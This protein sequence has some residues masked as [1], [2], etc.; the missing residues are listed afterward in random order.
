STVL[1]ESLLFA[2]TIRENIAYGW[3]NVTDADIEAAARLA[4]IHDFIATLP[5][6]Y[7]TVVGERGVTLSGGQR[8]RVAIARAAVRK[9]S[10]LILDEP[11][12][13]LDEENE[14][15]VMEALE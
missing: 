7:D 6:G 9:A 3:E 13:G 11:A 12:T 2:A 15:L 1:Q 8:Q 5:K 14:R 4:N 10:I